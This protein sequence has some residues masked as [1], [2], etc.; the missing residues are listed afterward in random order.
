[1]KRE[2]KNEENGKDGKFNWKGRINVKKFKTK[3]KIHFE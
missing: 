1:M 2:K 3:E